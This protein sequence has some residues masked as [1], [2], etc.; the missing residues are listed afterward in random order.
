VRLGCLRCVT[1]L[2]RAQEGGRA[3]GADG[4]VFLCDVNISLAGG[5]V[6]S[7]GSQLANPS[8]SFSGILG[9]R[10]PRKPVG[11]IRSLIQVDHALRRCQ[12]PIDG[13]IHNTGATIK[14]A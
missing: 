9:R 4:G 5:A 1:G 6:Q 14:I 3:D 2:N 12:N 13:A 7:D 11:A 8:Y 10:P